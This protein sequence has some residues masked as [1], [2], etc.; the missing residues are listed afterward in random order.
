MALFAPLL[1]AVKPPVIQEPPV[2]HQHTVVRQM[3]IE[4]AGERGIA[5][6]V[7]ADLQIQQEMRPERHQTNDPRLRICT[8]A[9]C[10]TRRQSEMRAILVTVRYPESRAINAEYRQAPPTVGV[11]LLAT[12]TSDNSIEQ[13]FEGGDSQSV[14]CLY[15]ARRTDRRLSGVIREDQMQMVT[16]R[17]N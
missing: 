12:M 7:R 15:Q 5:L 11:K 4:A 3:F 8:L 13:V 2:D 6:R 10:T 16:H 14:A 17:L 1:M 9:V